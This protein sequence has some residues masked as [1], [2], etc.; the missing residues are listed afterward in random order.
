MFSCAD[1]P[2]ILFHELAFFGG[3][4]IFS[5]L[6]NFRQNAIRLGVIGGGCK[7]GIFVDSKLGAK[8]LS[9]Q[10]AEPP[11]EILDEREVPS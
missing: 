5:L 11:I 8:P 6:M 4:G 1:F 10:A 3:E 2:R 7:L 9:F